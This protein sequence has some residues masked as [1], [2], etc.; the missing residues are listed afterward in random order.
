MVH[1]ILY[2]YVFSYFAQPLD[3]KRYI[4]LSTKLY[5]IDKPIIK[6]SG[7]EEVKYEIK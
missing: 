1:N 2:I 5:K 7:Q 3:R 6:T 4:V